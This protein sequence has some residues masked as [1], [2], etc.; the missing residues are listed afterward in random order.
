MSEKT[1]QI[2]LEHDFINN[3]KKF[4]LKFNG[5]MYGIFGE[6]SLDE[7]KT[8]EIMQLIEMMLND[9]HKLAER[10]DNVN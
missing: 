1:W 4:I 5:S 8:E 10:D 2:N 7:K 3:E 6:K 9:A